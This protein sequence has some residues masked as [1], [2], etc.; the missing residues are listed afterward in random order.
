MTTHF[1]E[2]L[3]D[4]QRLFPDEALYS[5]ECQHPNREA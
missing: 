2:S 3:P 4:F 1:P 5:G